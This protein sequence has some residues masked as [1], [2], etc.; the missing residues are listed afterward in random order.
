MK[1]LLAIALVAL[2]SVGLAID[3]SLSFPDA[4]IDTPPLSLEQSA[5]QGVPS[6]VF[7]FRPAPTVTRVS[8]MPILAPASECDPKMV[9]KPDSSVDYKLTVV[10][11]E[12][13]SEK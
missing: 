12:V 5:A 13:S 3:S 9:V 2:P 8:R 4:T 7:D 10:A 11:P 1:K 6:L